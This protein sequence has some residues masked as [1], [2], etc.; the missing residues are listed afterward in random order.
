MKKANRVKPAKPKKENYPDVIKSIVLTPLRII[1]L[2]TAVAG[3]FALVFE[4]RYFEEFSIKI[5]FGRIIATIISFTV[6]VAT[7]FDFGKKNPTLLVHVLLISIVA[8]FASI[9][10]LTLLVNSH[11][12]ALIIFT[13]SLFLSWDLKNQIVMAIYYNAIFAMAILLNEQSIYF[14]PNMFASVMFVMFIS[15]MSVFASSVNYKLRRGAI[16]KSVEARDIFENSSNGLFRASVNG[17]LISVNPAFVEMLGY[18]SKDELLQNKELNLFF[19]Y[20]QIYEHW[21]AKLDES[22]QLKNYKTE[23]KTNKSENLIIIKIDAR[24]V[25]NSDDSIKYYDGSIEDVTQ[26]VKSED[27]K[28]IAIEELKKAKTI[29]DENAHKAME[30]SE[31]KSQF[32]AKMNHEIRTPINNILL[33]LSM[34]QKGILHTKED[35]AEYAR[36]AVLSADALLNII[37]NNLDLSKLEAGKMELDEKELDIKNEIE[38]S[39]GL[40]APS[41]E[42]K[43]LKLSFNIEDNIPSK[44]IGDPNRIQQILVNLLSNAIK[45]TDEGEISIGVKKSKVSGSNIEILI[46]VKDTG[47]GIPE[48]NLDYIF[49]AYSQA[50]ESKIK[51]KGTGLGL[52]I[53]KELV[54]LMGGKIEVKSKLGKGSIFYFTIQLKSIDRNTDKVEEEKPKLSP[55]QSISKHGKILLVEDN[56][57]TQNAEGKL[58]NEMGY[59][60]DSISNGYDAITAVKSNKYKLILM[61]IAMPVMDGFTATQ[62]IRELKG[63]YSKIPIIAVTANSSIFDKEKC[64]AAGMDDYLSKPLKIPVLQKMIDKWLNIENKTQRIS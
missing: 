51:S 60:T 30:M 38:S 40:V 20:Q 54:K 31:D 18:S 45:F 24:C 37:N 11:L 63:E 10:F 14:L 19:K 55:K 43:K 8:S 9:I 29:A 50:K 26:L 48:E 62:K 5:Y 61:D 39:V 57:H 53:C 44:L 34:I 42:E 25:K 33:V 13:V 1:A 64:L 35:L 12:L 27:E 16:Q 47:H 32:L 56:L 59:E 7:Y 21:K 52:M 4:V 46:F 22:G 17:D 23:F 2:I 28:N 58:L 41:A 36:S 49:K 6:L 3:I 15:V